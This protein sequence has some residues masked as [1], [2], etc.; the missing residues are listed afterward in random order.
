VTSTQDRSRSDETR[1]KLLDAATTAFAERGFH[2]TT[3]RDIAA[4]AGMSPAAVYVHHRSKEELLYLISRR[5]HENTLAIIR[6]AV[7]DVTDPP[8]RL[9]AAVRAFAADHARAHTMARV[10]NYEL[11]ALDPEHRAEILELRRAIS[12]EVKALVQAGVDSGDFDVPD[13]DMAA[14]ALLS[15]GI[16]IARWYRTDGP[17]TPEE[18]GE[19]YAGLALRIVGHRG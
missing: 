15:L 16:D 13:V 19:G 9:A 7:A 1:A 14:R 17:S 8:G 12:R 5:G 2:A 11:G 10:V 18:I 6:A 3:T 4:A